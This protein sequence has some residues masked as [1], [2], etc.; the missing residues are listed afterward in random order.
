[1]ASPA[2]IAAMRR[3]LVLARTPDVPLGPNPRV[4]CILLDRDGGVVGSG[5]HRG[6]GYPHAEVD[7]LRTAG[8]RAR[9]ACAVVTLEPC[10]HTGRTGPCSAALFDA[11]IE[12]VVFAQHDSNPVARGGADALRRAG[13]DVEGGVLAGQARA[14]NPEWTFANE[15]GRPFVT[16]KFAATLDGRSAAA[17]GTSRWITSPEA[18]AD[19]HWLRGECDV[20]LVG[21]G[22]VIADDPWLTVRDGQGA[23]LERRFQPLRAVMGRRPIPV[24]AAAA[25]DAAETI[26]LAT[27]DPSEALAVL[28]N[29]GRHRVWLEGGPTLAAVF[30]REGLV[31]RIVGYLAPAVL[32]AG[33]AALGDLGITTVSDAVRLE[34]TDVAQVGPDLRIT[35]RPG[36]G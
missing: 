8:D 16:W 17:D 36:K 19:V 34:L 21:T 26:H 1:V 23:A 30:L 15:H 6:A 22:T 11:G 32:G 2:E 29:L 13:I 28:Y 31:D 5:Y 24:G 35:A 9:G 25:D 12:R 10:H 18:R 4:G 20:V 3:A 7:A 33:P 27:R 14:V